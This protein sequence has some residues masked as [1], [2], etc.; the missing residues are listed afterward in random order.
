[1]RDLYSMGR[2]VVSML[3]GKAEDRGAE[4]EQV[5][6]NGAAEDMNH[7]ET[8]RYIIRQKESGRTKEEI[9]EDLID[10]YKMSGLIARVSVE[11]VRW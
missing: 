4:Q 1:M 6:E 3:Q 9:F 10:N 5:C 2:A 8:I 11:S 7:T